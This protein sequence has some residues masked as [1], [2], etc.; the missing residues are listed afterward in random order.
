MTVIYCPYVFGSALNMVNL[1]LFSQKLYAHIFGSI[2]SH[3]DNLIKKKY[4]FSC[5]CK[6]ARNWGKFS[7]R[8]KYLAIFSSTS[9]VI[10]NLPQ[11]NFKLKKLYFYISFLCYFMWTKHLRSYLSM[12]LSTLFVYCARFLT[13]ANK[14]KRNK[15][16][17][18]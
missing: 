16:P 14:A 12:S 7:I 8:L 15:N 9:A 17:Q 13:N 18:P 4:S 6:I 10:E 5:L 1:G 2:K 11:L 3:N